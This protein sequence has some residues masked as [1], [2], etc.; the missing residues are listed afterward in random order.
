M[1]EDPS[2]PLDVAA[3]AEVLGRE[4]VPELVGM[5][6]KA[7]LLA[8]SLEELGDRLDPDRLAVAANQELG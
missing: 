1:A 8:D 6:R 3:L 2:E 5:N 4:G 7:R